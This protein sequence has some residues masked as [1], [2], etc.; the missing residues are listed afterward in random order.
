MEKITNFCQPTSQQIP[1]KI[2][3]IYS[4]KLYSPEYC[5]EIQSALFI[6]SNE[7]IWLRT[8]SNYRSISTVEQ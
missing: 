2:G 8:Q 5:L 4:W 6:G 7:K 3:F 1:R